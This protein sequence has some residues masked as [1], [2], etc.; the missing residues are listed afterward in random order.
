MPGKSLRVKI[1]SD[2][3]KMENKK[4]YSINNE[5]SSWKEVDGEIVIINLE[6]T[7]YYSLNK[8]GTFIW[9]QLTNNELNFNEI[10]LMTCEAFGQ[11]EKNIKDDVIELLDHFEEENL[12]VVK[13]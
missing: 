1:K 4:K 7:H 8:T 13:E 9:N 3:G 12:V 10:I 6:T 2:T 5:N 11:E